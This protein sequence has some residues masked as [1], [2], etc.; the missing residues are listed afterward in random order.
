MNNC[1]DRKII[2][3]GGI[4]GV[5][6]TTLCKKVSEELT[7][8]HYSAS[9]LIFNL[10]SENTIKDKQVSDVRKNQDDL[11][12]AVNKYFNNKEYYLLDGHFC[13]LNNKWD[14]TKVPLDTFK[15]LG[16]RVIIVLVDDESEVLK[17]L[18]SRDAKNYSID[19]IKKFQEMEISYAQE[20]AKCIGVKCKIFNA[21]CDDTEILSFIKAILG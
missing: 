20:I 17:R 14:I 10:K 12:S 9:N 5:G 2:F 11:L 7:I 4:H 19:L 1:K 3:V 6:K 13:L 21:S 18:L 16:I 15:D 8:K